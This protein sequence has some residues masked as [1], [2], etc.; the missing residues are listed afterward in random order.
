MLLLLDVEILALLDGQRSGKD[1]AALVARRQQL[2]Q[3]WWQT[4][5][6]EVR[7]VHPSATRSPPPAT[8]STAP[9]DV[10]ATRFHGMPV[11]GGVAVGQ[12]RRL[13]SPEQG[14]RLQLGEILLVPSTDPAWT[15]L[16]LKAGGL[17]MET[18]GFLSHGAIVARE[19]GIPAVVNLPGILQ[20]L[21]EGETVEVDGDRGVI[22]RV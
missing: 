19:F 2:E 17:I 8:L 9:L 5:V 4:T 14:Q 6:P 3:Q 11:G 12:V 1:L 18:G 7:I 16:F 20:A 21:E 22:R 15:P 13:Y 10:T